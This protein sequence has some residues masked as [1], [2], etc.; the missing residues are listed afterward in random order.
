MRSFLL[1]V[2]AGAVVSL[3][4]RAQEL[5][6]E[7]GVVFVPDVGEFACEGV[8]LVG[9]LPLDAFATADSP[10]ADANND[11]WG[12]TDPETGT[13]Y[14]LVGTENG[15][16]FVDL[17]VPTQPRLVGKLPTTTFPSAWR[18]VKTYES[19]AFVV[20]DGA[21]NHGMQVFDLRRLRGV[22]GGAVTFE[23]DAVY[24]GIGSAHNVVVNEETGFAYAVGFKPPEPTAFRDD[25]CFERGFHAINIQDPQNPT[26]AGCFSDAAVDTAP[27]IVPGYTHDA[28]CV[29]Y[30]GPDADYAGRELCVAANENEVTVF[31]VTDKAA[32]RV[33]SQAEYP[34]DAYTHQGW[35]TEDQRFFL[36]NDELD[37]VQGGRRTQ[38]T[39]VFDLQDL[40]A[41]EFAFD[42]DSGLT[43]ID[44]NLYVRDGLVFESNY[45]AGLRILDA[46]EIERGVVREVAFFDTFPG[47]TSISAPC[48]PPNTERQCSSF[49]GQ[50]SN[51]P[52][53]AS[54]LVVANDRNYGLFVLRPD[55]LQGQGTA[56]PPAPEASAFRLSEP[57]PNPAPG[58]AR[59]TLRVG[60]TQAVRADLYDLAGRHVQALYAGDVGAG[61]DLVLTVEGGALPAGVYVVRV[62]GRDAEATRRLVL[63]R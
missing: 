16:A 18:D 50:W 1:T 45:E 54:G 26:F 22:E 56:T 48:L 57:A 24:E 17:S 36:A 34:G 53:F 37:E 41:P 55:V 47:S 2:L 11:V 63:T 9:Y 35:L 39:I 5:S 51:Y 19:H 40:D 15:M 3:P 31:D 7:G 32:V 14:A 25:P 8:D 29:V 38:R 58:S 59:L 13:E 42:Y 30:R 46:R 61:R 23:P 60:T 49:N 33:V 28:Q 12:W 44:H 10:A 20:A 27:V 43:T 52:Y 62:V 4:A 6:C 21:G